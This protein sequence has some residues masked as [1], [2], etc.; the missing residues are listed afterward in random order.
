MTTKNLNL[1]YKIVLNL[2]E[3]NAKVLDLGCGNGELLTNKFS[4]S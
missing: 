3:K 4:R 1:N 2:I